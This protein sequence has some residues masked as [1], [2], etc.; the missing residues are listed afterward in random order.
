MGYGV[1]IKASYSKTTL[2]YILPRN[3]WRLFKMN[4]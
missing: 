1:R 3:F 4:L 2:R